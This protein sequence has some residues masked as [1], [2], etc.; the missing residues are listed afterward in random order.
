MNQIFCVLIAVIYCVTSSVPPIKLKNAASD[1]SYIPQ[2]GLGNAIPVPLDQQYDRG[3]SAATKW[4][5]VG[6]T[7]FDEAH[8]YPSRQGVSAGVLNYTEHYTKIKRKDLFIASKVGGCSG[9]YLGETQI[10]KQVYEVLDLWNT[11]YIDLMLLHWS[12]YDYY[13][14]FVDN[15]T[16]FSTDPYCQAYMN[17]TFGAQYNASLCRQSSWRGLI[18]L[19]LNG[20]VKAI[21]VSNF[22]E[23]H[24]I[25]I[26]NYKYNGKYYLPTLNQMQFHGYWHEYDLL[27][28]CKKY[29]IQY[30]SW[31]TTGAPD[32]QAN[33]WTGNTP[34]LPLHP[35]AINI[36]EKY[37]KSAAQVWLRWQR[38]LGVIPIPRSNNIT[39][40]K[41]NMDIFDFELSKEDMDQL[42]NVTAPP[43]YANLVYTPST[44]QDPNNLP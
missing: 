7:Y 19:F 13:P 3:Y 42:Y 38:Q 37:K 26:I 11:T 44:Q 1:D 36:G 5:S 6:G 17:H 35:I 33:I 28:Y 41:E 43:Y 2:V 16:Q 22:E 8:C 20:T 30:N 23:K 34:V 15:G 39:H 24:L 4:L 12:A 25:D 32:V 40:M 18:K 21:G 10:I 14:Y 31:A 9:N 27:N 29:N